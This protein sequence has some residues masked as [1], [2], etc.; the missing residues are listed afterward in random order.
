MAETCVL[1]HAWTPGRVLCAV[2]GFGPRAVQ[3]G[4]TTPVAQAEVVAAPE[5]AVAGA[6]RTGRSL[7]LDEPAAYLAPA[8]EPDVP[9]MVLSPDG[10]WAWDGTQWIPA[11][12]QPE[13]APQADLLP[14]PTT[15]RGRR[16]R[17]RGKDVPAAATTEPTGVADLATA[18]DHASR[19]ARRADPKLLILLVL[20]L[21]IAAAADLALK[22]PPLG[23]KTA[24]ASSAPI[25]SAAA[26]IAH[27]DAFATD[28]LRGGA[29][30]EKAY[31]AKSGLYTSSVAQLVRTGM[32]PV[33]APAV[34]AAQAH[35]GTGFCLVSGAEVTGRRFFLYDSV[36]G[37]VRPTVFATEAAALQGCSQQG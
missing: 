30:S 11:P 2:C 9:A 17:R 33:A 13:P 35:H 12:Q 32:P 29:L 28:I 19:T 14:E 36:L 7:Q 10:Q 26:T 3:P 23:H 37:G 24:S 22:L 31:R 25:V 15:R 5:L 27:Q 8:A 20:V 34:F 1:G 21:A 4:Q 18:P 16:S 6:A